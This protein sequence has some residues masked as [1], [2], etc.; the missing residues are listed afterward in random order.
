M[1]RQDHGSEAKIESNREYGS[2]GLYGTGNAGGGG[3]VAFGAAGDYE[4]LVQAVVNQV[5]GSSFACF[6]KII[7]QLIKRERE[8]LAEAEECIRWYQREVEKHTNSIQ[9]LEDLRS[10]LSD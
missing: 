1:E 5:A 3:P 7:D 9:E 8:K 2:Q 6:G 10:Q 4:G